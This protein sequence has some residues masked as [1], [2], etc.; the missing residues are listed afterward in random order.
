MV[1]NIR[2]SF[3]F[4]KLPHNFLLVIKNFC[5]VV[6][7]FSLCINRANRATNITLTP[8]TAQQL[9]CVSEPLDFHFVTHANRLEQS[10]AEVAII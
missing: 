9:L 4:M 5:T 8:G 10:A 1:Q 6:C 3:I 2:Q 7:N